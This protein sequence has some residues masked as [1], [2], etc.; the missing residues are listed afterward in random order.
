MPTG[1]KEVPVLDTPNI[2]LKAGPSMDDCRPCCSKQLKNKESGNKDRDSGYQR[3]NTRANASRPF[4][5]K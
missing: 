2:E 3:R 5:S 4:P 1:T